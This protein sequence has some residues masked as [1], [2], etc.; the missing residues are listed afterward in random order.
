[1]VEATR[2][3]QGTEPEAERFAQNKWFASLAALAVMAGVGLLVVTSATSHPPGVGFMEDLQ[4]SFGGEED[5]LEYFDLRKTAFSAGATNTRDLLITDNG[6]VPGQSVYADGWVSARYHD[7]SAK[8]DPDHR[9]VVITWTDSGTT[10][11]EFRGFP[12]SVSHRWPD[13]DPTE[14]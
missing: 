5:H 11:E 13:A 9:C 14:Q 4:E 3:A 2:E 1:M 7:D 10:F 6:R 12:C 8:D